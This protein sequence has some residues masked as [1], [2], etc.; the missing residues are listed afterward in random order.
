MMCTSDA[1][2]VKRLAV[3]LVACN[4]AETAMPDARALTW[5]RYLI[6]AGQHTAQVL[7]AQPKNPLQGVTDAVGRDYELAL[8]AT[9]IYVLTAPVQPDDQL[10]WNKLPGLSD[11][12]EV[13]LAKDGAMFAWRWRPELA[14]LEITAYANNAGTHLQTDPLFLLDADDLGA[15]AALRYRVW[16]EPSAYHFD[17]T[18]EVRGRAITA[19]TTLPRRCSETPLDPLAWA[20]AFYFGGTST[21]PHDITARIRESLWTP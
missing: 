18:G 21:A 6:P 20:G 12:D 15:D 19:T 5:S 17:V 9:A 11:C 4:S 7:D 16:R 10:D 1:P 8:D 2:R 13:D 3:P 14:V